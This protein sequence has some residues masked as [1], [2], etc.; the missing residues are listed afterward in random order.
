MSACVTFCVSEYFRAQNWHEKWKMYWF[1]SFH[2]SITV[3]S[4]QKYKCLFF[5]SSNAVT[6]FYFIL[7]LKS[8]AQRSVYCEAISLHI[9]IHCF[10]WVN[11]KQSEKKSFRVC[12]RIIKIF[13]NF[14]VAALH[15]QEWLETWG[16]INC[17]WWQHRPTYST[18]TVC[19]AN[20]Q[21]GDVCT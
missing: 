5:F 4:P 17:S 15:R 7:E 1:S 6:I 18:Y 13:L 19:N 12:K 3:Y 16:V 11:L 8:F 10:N 21:I 20:L 2:V 14:N 9:K